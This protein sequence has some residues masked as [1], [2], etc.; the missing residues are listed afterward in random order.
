MKFFIALMLLL[1]S[2]GSWA[3]GYTVETVPNVKLI[4]NSYVSNPDNIISESAAGQIDTMLDS[5]EKKTTAQVAV[6][7]VNSIGEEDIFD[8]AQA[9]FV[10]WGIG[11]ADK[12][13]GLLILFV[14]D[15]R[16]V[17]FHTGYGLES[18]LTDAVCK[19][20][21]QQDMVPFFKAGDYDAGMIAGVGRVVSILTDPQAAEEIRSETQDNGGTQFLYAGIMVT[22]VIVLVFAFFIARSNNR[23][24][25]SEDKNWI[26]LSRARWLVLYIFLPYAFL[27]TAF[28]FEWNIVVFALAAYG[29][30]VFLFLERRYRIQQ[31]VQPLLTVGDNQGAY[32]FYAPQ[33]T[34][35]IWS[36]I[37]FPVP[38]LLV[39]FMYRRNMKRYRNMPRACKQCGGQA[40]KLDEKADDAFLQA[41]QIAEERVGSID[42]DVWRCTACQAAELLAYPDANTDYTVCSKCKAKTY[43]LY[44]TR[45]LIDATYSASGQGEK[46]YQC[47]H[48][49]K[50]SVRKFKIPMRVASTSSSSSG[51][52]SS[53]SS[54]S[55]GGSW[56]GGSSGGGGSSSSW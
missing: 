54:S 14:Q 4:N 46:T 31:L 48:C 8:F 19:H 2:F 7:L 23:F 9:L 13:N 28:F 53:S 49:Q 11:Q 50:R 55:S 25:P 12:D 10:K 39:Y 1:V 20:I 42:Y 44:S 29:F 18:T 16:T 6:V 40:V 21:Q 17:R 51:S 27:L 5:L 33:R 41:A 37:F 35:L 34:R 36:A 15:Q 52:S 45:T 32:Y 24:K 47:E 43:H 30:L 3:Q 56:G 26:G 38:M 22:L